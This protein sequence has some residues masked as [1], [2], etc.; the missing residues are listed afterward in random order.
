MTRATE[1]CR[2]QPL[3]TDQHMAITKPPKSGER[4]IKQRKVNNFWSSRKSRKS[5]LPGKTL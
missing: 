3:C 1:V 2:E 5:P 4:T